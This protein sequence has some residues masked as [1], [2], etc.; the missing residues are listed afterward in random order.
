MGRDESSSWL[1]PP[2]SSSAAAAV[3]AAAAASAAYGRG[4]VTLRRDPP[5]EMRTVAG[6][7]HP[8][9][10]ARCCRVASCVV[11]RYKSR[12]R[13]AR[14]GAQAARHW[15]S[16]RR[17]RRPR[18]CGQ[19]GASAACARGAGAGAAAAR[20]AAAGGRG[21]VDVSGHRA[22]KSGWWSSTRPGAPSP[23]LRAHRRGRRPT[24]AAARL[25][26]ARRGLGQVRALPEAQ[27]GVPEGGREGEGRGALRGGGRG[28][29]PRAG[30][31]ARRQGLPHAQGL[32][33]RQAQTSRLPGPA[34]RVGST[35]RLS[36]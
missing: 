1:P 31:G 33:P 8:P 3:A 29:A 9:P 16:R 14:H 32:R 2:S 13:A 10:C 12:A 7:P 35:A 5:S 34:G 11:G 36:D 24:A 28:P 30:P 4:P 15:G 26:R 18:A 6:G 22:S 20:A 23:A 27:A 21:G 17:R 25:T 19:D